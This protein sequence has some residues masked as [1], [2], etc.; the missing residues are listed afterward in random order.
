MGGA[1]VLL[2]P[3]SVSPQVSL[4][5]LTEEF[6]PEKKDFLRASWVPRGCVLK[7]KSRCCIF[8]KSA[9]E[10][11]KCHSCQILSVNTNH[12]AYLYS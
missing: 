10:V 7:I 12:M 4:D 3:D 9:W 8:L 1:T 6:A 2:Y 11:V 5:L